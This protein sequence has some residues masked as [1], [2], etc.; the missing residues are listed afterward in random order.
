MTDTMKRTKAIAL[1]LA[2]ALPL[3]ACATGGIDDPLNNTTLYSV[4]Q[5]VVER[6]NYTLDL[7]ATA[8]GLTAPEQ[9]RLADW[10]ETMDVGY[11]DRIAIDDPMA[12]PAVYEDVA[13][14]AGRYG[15]LIS[16]TAPVT[17]GYV[18]PGNVRIVVTRSTAYVPD[19]PNWSHKSTG[20]Y[21]NKTSPGFGCSINGN[22]AAMIANPEHLLEGEAGTGETTVMS[23]TKAIDVYRNAT[24][25]GANGLPAVA[26]DGN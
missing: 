11:G 23:S 21:E 6:S 15:L 8:G 5:P 17:A 20:N 12:S 22:L 2:A 26:S 9:G 14:V 18:D 7:M 3:G 24:P 1:A 13:A 25:T 10:F 16:E 19:C 4:N